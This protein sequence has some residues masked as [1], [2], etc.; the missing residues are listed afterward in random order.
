[1]LF[2]AKLENAIA[3]ER[4]VDRHNDA[5]SGVHLVDLFQGQHVRQRVHTGPA[6]RLGH[7][8]TH[9]AELAHLVDRLI[10]KFARLIVVGGHLG[11]L[12]LGKFSRRVANH[13]V[14]FIK[15]EIHRCFL[16]V[17]LEEWK[18]G[19]LGNW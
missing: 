1:M 17:Q 16:L 12:I 6:V 10:R 3:E 18:A 14:L 7:L 9:E 19:K 8:D 11:D 15:L 4:A 2:S 13:K 5:V